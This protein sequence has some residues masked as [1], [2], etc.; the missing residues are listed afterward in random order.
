MDTATQPGD[1]RRG[2]SFAPARIHEVTPRGYQTAR[3]RLWP[4]VEDDE[5]SRGETQGAE[6]KH[7]SKSRPLFGD[8]SRAA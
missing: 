6:S 5:M 3:C 7:E 2:E 8:F 4:N 1:E